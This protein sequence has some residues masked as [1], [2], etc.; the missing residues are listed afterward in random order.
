MILFALLLVTDLPRV[1]TNVTVSGK[2]GKSG[3]LDPLGWE[4][5]A[6]QNAS[7]D[8]G[9]PP[10]S[11]PRGGPRAETGTG[12]RERESVRRAACGFGHPMGEPLDLGRPCR[13]PAGVAGILAYSPAPRCP[14]S[15][16]AFLGDIRL[17]A[18]R[19]PALTGPSRAV[20]EN[21]SSRRRVTHLSLEASPALIRTRQ[22]A[23]PRGGDAGPGAGEGG[24]GK[25]SGKGPGRQI[26][27]LLS[28]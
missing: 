12:V 28:H 19:G 16:P 9:W 18:S 4:K 13:G 23:T 24:V 10:V 3:P 17:G 1:E 27:N 2:Q 22:R 20:S 25:V 21:W 11:G 15:V 6:G 5:E 26:A 7:A 8:T 14:L